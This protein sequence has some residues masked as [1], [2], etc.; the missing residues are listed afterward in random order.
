MEF[1]DG[2]DVQTKIA[3]LKKE[4]RFMKEEDIWVIFYDMVMGL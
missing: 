2:G 1:A 3:E 4:G